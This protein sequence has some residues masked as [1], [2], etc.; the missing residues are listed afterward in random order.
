MLLDTELMPLSAIT[1]LDEVLLVGIE[2]SYKVAHKERG[3]MTRT[4]ASNLR[5]INGHLE[6]LALEIE[7][8]TNEARRVYFLQRFITGEVRSAPRRSWKND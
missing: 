6:H 8:Q 5:K 1:N 3:Q 7:S 4:S 2:Q